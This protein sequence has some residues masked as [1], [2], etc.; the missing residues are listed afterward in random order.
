MRSVSCTSLPQNTDCSKSE[1]APAT[2]Q[3][4]PVAPREP[5]LPDG[6]DSVSANFGLVKNKEHAKDVMHSVFQRDFPSYPSYCRT[7][8][9]KPPVLAEV[10]TR[11]SRYFSEKASET[12]SSFEYQSIPKPVLFDVHSKLSATNFKMDSDPSKVNSF[13]TT[14]KSYFT[15]KTDPTRI[16]PIKNSRKSYIPQGDIE[17][18]HLPVSNYRDHFQGYDTNVHR[19][20]KAP[21]MHE[22]IP[23]TIKGGR[24]TSPLQHHTQ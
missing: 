19:V 12:V 9:A 15:S 24:S 11:D 6:T 5:F 21:P 2:E 14:H 1:M 7:E 17:K 20:E 8:G 18:I 23:S 16:P 3:A 10:M 4:P 22:G 13:Q